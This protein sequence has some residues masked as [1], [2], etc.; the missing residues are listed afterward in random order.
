[1]KDSSKNLI[2]SV[3]VT[4]A[5]AGVIAIILLTIQILNG[6]GIINIYPIAD[7]ITLTSASLLIITSSL[8]STIRT[9]VYFLRATR[10]KSEIKISIDIEG[11][12]ISLE[13]NNIKD[14]EELLRRYRDLNPQAEK[15]DKEK[16]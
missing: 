11:T 5:I 1:M 9:L 8:Y 13:S 16:K 10:K 3:G 12:K 4:T 14:A 2:S 7:N 15:I 6:L